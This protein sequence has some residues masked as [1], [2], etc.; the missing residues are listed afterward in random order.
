MADITMCSGGGCFKK[1]SCY[2]HKA[3]AN[4]D[5][6]AWFSTPPYRDNSTSNNCDYYW[7]ILPDPHYC[8][9]YVVDKIKN[10]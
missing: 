1:E 8:K 4:E 9:I 6:Q 10:L 7:P 3:K 2:R 5:R